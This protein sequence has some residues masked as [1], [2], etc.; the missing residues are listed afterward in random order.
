M[1]N[2]SFF[3]SEIHT[4]PLTAEVLFDIL[5]FH[6]TNSMLYGIIVSA[7]VVLVLVF[8]AM[9]TATRPKSGLAFVFESLMEYVL[10]T[11]ENNLGSRERA[12]KFMPLFFTLFVLILFSN[13]SG[14][15][16]GVETIRLITSG[17]DEAALFRSFTTDLNATLAMAIVVMSTVHF[18]SVRYLGLKGYFQHFFTSEPLKPI[19]IFNGVIDIMG[20]LIR[21]VTLSMRLFGVIYA[22]D[23]LI[24]VLGQIAGPLGWAAMV[25]A[26]LLEIFF[27]LIQA[28]LFMMLSLVYLSIATSHTDDPHSA[29]DDHPKGQTLA[30]GSAA[31]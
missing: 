28:Y 12:L 19:N 6:F 3:A 30:Q 2:L 8:A 13:L 21:I 9:R 5:G 16:P 26:I 27:S 24:V 20:E 29:E 22:G 25:P 14:L 11:A 17:G 18:Y 7:V 10:D 15:M 23:V 4:T 31:K 1:P